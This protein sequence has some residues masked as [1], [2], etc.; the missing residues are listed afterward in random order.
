[1]AIGF[2]TLESLVT[3]PDYLDHYRNKKVLITGHTGF[4]GAWLSLWLHTLGAKVTGI[5]LLPENQDR[6][7][8]TAIQLD[9]EINSIVADLRDLP[10]LK[11]IITDN[12]PEI[13]FHLGAQSLVRRSY[14]EPVNTFETNVMGTLNLLE[15][16]RNCTSIKAVV[17]VTSDKCYQNQELGKAFVEGDPMGGHDPYSASKACA[18]LITD[19]Y[20]RC[21]FLDPAS[22][23]I[24]TARA[25]NVIGGG[26]WCEDRLIPDIARSI[27]QNRPVEIRNPQSVRPWQHVFEPLRGYLMLGARLDAGEQTFAEAWNLGPESGDALSVQHIAE[28]FIKTWGH[29]SLKKRTQKIPLHE[30]VLLTLDIKKAKERLGFTPVLN[31][32]STLK[33]TANWYRQYLENPM[34][35][36]SLCENQ[37]LNYSQKLQ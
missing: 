9:R 22:A 12:E 30:A 10:V 21:F 13:I 32:D 18:E 5:S 35:A 19:A 3:M 23:L 37:L 6:N 24:A 1:M 15:V 16:I 17:I 8:F 29:G 14:A 31:M 4:K 7:L 27:E 26:D 33:L 34:D 36:K 2:G 25:G 20:R 11:S 28:Q